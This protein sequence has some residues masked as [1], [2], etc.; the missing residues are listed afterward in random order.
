MKLKAAV[1]YPRGFF[2]YDIGLPVQVEN[3]DVKK[4]M[5]SVRFNKVNVSRDRTVI[6]NNEIETLFTKTHK[7]EPGVKTLDFRERILKAAIAAFG[8]NSFYDWCELQL[9]NPYFTDLHKRFMND[10]FRFIHTG[11]RQLNINSWDRLVTVKQA[12]ALDQKTPFLY[13]EYFKM[14]QVALFRRSFA[15][16]GTIQSWVSQPGGFEDMLRSL[17]IIFCDNPHLN[18][19]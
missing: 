17:R 9:E 4:L 2:G 16:N 8:T 5:A 18:N 3:T 19:T 12:S 7:N 11:E 10:T 1:V 13:R 15:V 6:S 14:D